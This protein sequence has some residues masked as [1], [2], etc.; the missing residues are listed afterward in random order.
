MLVMVTK[1]SFCED[2]IHQ[3]SLKI[4]DLKRSINENDVEITMLMDQ[5]KK[6]KST[7]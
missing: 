7:S 5:L 3:M 6:I 1:A 4:E 2:H